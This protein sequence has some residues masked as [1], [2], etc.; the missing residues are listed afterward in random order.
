VV[1]ALVLRRLVT[2]AMLLVLLLLAQSARA[3][4]ARLA[5]IDPDPELEAALRTALNPW[6]TTVLVERTTTPTNAMPASAEQAGG[7]STRLRAQAVVWISRSEQGP[8][9]W[10]YDAREHRVIVRPLDSSPPF[11]PTTAAAVALM[12]KTL[13]RYS[14]VPPAVE[15]VLPPPRQ[16]WFSLALLGGARRDTAQGG[17]FELRAGVLA[18][19]WP[20]ALSGK[21]GAGVELL[22]GPGQRVDSPLFSGHWSETGVLLRARGRLDLA[23]I[24]DVGGSLGGGLDVTTLTG[25]IVS[26]GER[27]R[28]LRVNPS[29]A[30]DA[31][32]GLR[33]T[34]ATRLGLR[35]GVAR[36]LRKQTYL[37]HGAPFFSVEAL[38]FQGFLL[39]E[40]TPF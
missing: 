29:L 25:V 10:M 16:R 31:E 19:L 6:R 1:S 38:R 34:A 5:L 11:D 21:F 40:L 9:L 8:A 14:E 22:S 27:S 12:V 37:A 7:I 30:A 26:S 24:I 32:L 39:V 2:L 17:S 3:D 28:A 33:P 18:T 36:P 20:R 4:A 15:R 13:L 23:P 35:I